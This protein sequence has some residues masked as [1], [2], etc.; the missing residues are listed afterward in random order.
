M[1]MHAGQLRKG[2]GDKEQRGNR[3]S[4]IICGVPVHQAVDCRWNFIARKER[5]GP[6]TKNNLK[7]ETAAKL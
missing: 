4:V 5:Q 1:H 7:P 2:L 3:P 6:C